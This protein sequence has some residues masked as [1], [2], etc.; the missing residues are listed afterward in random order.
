MAG[1]GEKA[2]LLAEEPEVDILEELKA[3]RPLH[4]ALGRLHDRL[5]GVASEREIT[6]YDRMHHRHNRK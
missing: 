5:V 3:S 4:P 2:P 6:S 1:L